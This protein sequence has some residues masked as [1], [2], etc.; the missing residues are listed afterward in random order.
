M[1]NDMPGCA[2]IV[3][4]AAKS[5]TTRAM[6]ILYPLCCGKAVRENHIKMKMLFSLWYGDFFVPLCGF[7]CFTQ[8]RKDTKREIIAICILRSFYKGSLTRYSEAGRLPF[9]FLWCD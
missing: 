9:Y 3:H 4:Q 8:R 1:P 5:M 2:S 6:R 7:F